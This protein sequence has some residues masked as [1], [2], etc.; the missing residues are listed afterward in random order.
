MR[1][2]LIQRVDLS[3]SF[4]GIDSVN[5]FFWA[6][7]CPLEVAVLYGYFTP[8]QFEPLRPFVDTWLLSSYSPWPL[9][10]AAP[11]HAAGLIVQ[12]LV[13]RTKDRFMGRTAE[14]D[15]GA[16][17]LGQSDSMSLCEYLKHLEP[18]TQ[19]AVLFTDRTLRAEKATTVYQDTFTMISIDWWQWF[20]SRIP[21]NRHSEAWMFLALTHPGYRVSDEFYR[22]GISESLANSMAEQGHQLVS[23]FVSFVSEA[24]VSLWT[25]ESPGSS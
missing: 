21:S 8:H 17:I 16:S 12:Q 6:M 22:L 24:I 11:H 15:L 18:S 5:R 4:R 3:T 23:A 14:L 25:P 1:L 10:I 13:S 19:Y 20:Q 2:C 7:C 9:D